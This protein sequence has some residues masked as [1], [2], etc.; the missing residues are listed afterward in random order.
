MDRLV[1]LRKARERMKIVRHSSL[2]LGLFFFSGCATLLYQLAWQRALVHL[3]GVQIVSLS[4]VV[5][6]FLAGLGVGSVLGGVLSRVPRLP[7][8]PVFCVL[9]LA[10]GVFGVFSLDVLD[11]LEALTATLPHVQ[12]ACVAFGFVLAPTLLMGATLPLLLAHVVGRDAQRRLEIGAALGRLYCVNTYGA[13]AACLV[14]ALWVFAAL[15]LDGTVRLAA[16]LNVAVALGA[17]A[18]CVGRRRVRD[19]VRGA[20]VSNAPPGCDAGGLPLAPMAGVA[21]LA[22]AVSL[23]YEIVWARAYGFFM[24]G[25]PAVLPVLLAVLLSGTAGGAWLGHRLCGRA[26]GLHHLGVLVLVASVV[27]FAVVPSLAAVSVFGTGGSLWLATMMLGA[28]SFAAFG[29]CLPLLAQCSVRRR[30][31]AGFAVGLLYGANFAGAVVAPLGVGLWAMDRFPLPTISVL[32]LV[33]GCAG[34]ALLFAW[35]ARGGLV[36]VAVAIAASGLWLSPWAHDALYARLLLKG[37]V[38]SVGIEGVVER[39]QGV[40]LVTEDAHVFGGGVYDGT[41]R[42]DLLDAQHSIVRPFLL[43]AFHPAPRR[44]LLVGLGSGAWAQ[45]LAHHRDLHELVVV[46]IHPGYRALLAERAVLRSLASN[47]KVRLVTDDVRRWLRR[48]RGERFDA[49]IANYPYH[50][51]TYA[52]SVLSCEMLMRVR[53]H[54]APRGVYLFNPTRSGEAMR[55]AALSAPHVALVYGMVLVA[56]TPEGVVPDV[57]RLDRVLSSYRIDGRRVLDLAQPLHRA[58]LD[59]VLSLVDPEG[60]HWMSQ[61][62]LLA[63]TSGLDVVTDR[64]LRTEWPRPGRWGRGADR[65]CA[66]GLGSAVP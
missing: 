19:V 46:D 55:T 16:S 63:V 4:I 5:S 8:L 50:W 28:A 59:A 58:R 61:D 1:G 21:A 17:I 18:L 56:D 36:A 26:I 30:D 53:S 3:L 13:A 60:P 32:L 37:H 52:S 15:G 20:P 38:G 62:A 44:I 35:S 57:A 40:I 54:L 34:A 39:S 49:V 31:R 47:P 12:V 33:L 29:V 23:G 10:L 41:A 66:Q 24:G 11:R 7:V 42:V 65:D 45:A 48:H 25:F 22:G 14:A 51:R 27:G 6:A 9:E 64:N 2:L 43:S